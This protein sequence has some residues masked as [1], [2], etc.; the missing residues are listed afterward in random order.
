V[1][2]KLA[3]R[4]EAAFA[5]ARSLG[6]AALLCYLPAGFPDRASS[7][8]ALVAA[9]RSGAD[10]LE[11]GIPYSDPV[12]DGPAIQRAGQ[13]ALDQGMSVAGAIEL[14][15]AVGR[16]SG[17]P[18]VFMTYYPLVY[19]HG[20]ERFAREAAG[21]GAAGVILPDLP[22]EE[23]GP[24]REAAGAQGLATVFL[25]APTSTDER[26]RAIGV[27]SR[28]FI[29]CA[30]RLGVT[31]VRD[32]LAGGVEEMVARVRAVTDLPLAVGI[33]VSNALQAAEVARVADGVIVGSALV[34]A[35]LDAISPAE[36]VKAV[37]ELVR[38]LAAGVASTARPS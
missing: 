1:T 38:R 18:Y 21:A 4:L 29:Y 36:S 37:G 22:P 33:G 25:A 28:G 6:R 3:S 26:L 35:M 5:R 2:E 17:T 30:S 20:L 13:M 15:R 8:D 27:I 23:A 31:G 34:D 9:A 10:V 24:W 12:M 11:I 14:G 7:E 19:R 16:R 32:A